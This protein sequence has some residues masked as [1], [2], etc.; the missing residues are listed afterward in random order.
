[1][2]S[3]RRPF[4]VRRRAVGEY[5]QT[6]DV[7]FFKTT[8]EDT[9]FTVKASLQPVK[10]NEM[11]L[12]PENRRDNSLLKMYTDTE[13][14]T[15]EKGSSGNADIVQINGDDYEVVQCLPWLNGVINHYK[16]FVAKR[17]TNDAEPTQETP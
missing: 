13:L 8:A 3:F 1:M 6:T 11:A 12:L 2:S 9:T 5:D 17:T 16:V 14:F 10:G 7:G 15:S 4:I